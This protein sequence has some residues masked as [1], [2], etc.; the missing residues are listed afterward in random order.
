[1]QLIAPPLYVMTT[2]CLD[3]AAGI[4]ALNTAIAAVKRVIEARGGQLNV[5]MAVRRRVGDAGAAALRA[6]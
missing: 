5:K 6:H 3:K 1:M 4:E 2:A